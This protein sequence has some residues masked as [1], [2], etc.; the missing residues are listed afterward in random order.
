[1]TSPSSMSL[2]SSGSVNVAGKDQVSCDLHGAAAILNV[3]SGTYYGLNEVGSTVWNLIQQPRSVEEICKTLL[4]EYEV[5]PA[6]CSSD[7]IEV[8]SAEDR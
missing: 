3:R 7:L 2:L 5:E 8:Q 6:R 4:R 1:M